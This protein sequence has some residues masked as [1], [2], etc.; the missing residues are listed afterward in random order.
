MT[1]PLLGRGPD[2]RLVT[3]QERIDKQ[4]APQRGGQ[5]GF[6]LIAQGLAFACV[7]AEFLVLGFDC[8]CKTQIAQGV[9]MSAADPCIGW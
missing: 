2:V 1:G 5:S 4:F 3:A 7:S 8:A 6:A 9:F